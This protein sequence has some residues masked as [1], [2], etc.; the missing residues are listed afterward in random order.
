MAKQ[1]RCSTFYIDYGGPEM[2]ISELLEPHPDV[3]DLRVSTPGFDCPNDDPSRSIA[4]QIYA[5]GGGPNFREIKKDLSLAAVPNYRNP[6]GEETSYKANN[7]F[8][9]MKS[10]FGDDFELESSMACAMASI[11]TFSSSAVKFQP[12]LFATIDSAH[13][14]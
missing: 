2:N 13:A 11:L 7:N 12:N 5:R 6:Y 3:Y 10:V 9:G 4:W 1:A 14:A 8:T